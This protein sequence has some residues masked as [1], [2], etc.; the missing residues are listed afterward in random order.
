MSFDFEQPVDDHQNLQKAK[1]N[2]TENDECEK[3]DTCLNDITPLPDNDS[4]LEED[5][6]Y[7]NEIIQNNIKH[8]TKRKTIPHTLIQY[9]KTRKLKDK[10]PIFLWMPRP[11]LNR[12]NIDQNVKAK[13]GKK[14]R[15]KVYFEQIQRPEEMEIE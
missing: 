12:W 13:A 9:N 14:N 11:A 5:Q 3:Y 10:Q 15:L 7:D 2:E 4:D 6:I 1:L 8:G